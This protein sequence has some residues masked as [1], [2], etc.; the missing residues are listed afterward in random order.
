[1]LHLS[2]GIFA[3]EKLGVWEAHC[4][5]GLFLVGLHIH[6]RALAVSGP[7]DHGWRAALVAFSCVSLLPSGEFG[8]EGRL[9]GF[10]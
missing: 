1:M 10:G 6:G 4:Y 2:K 9:P 7:L 3:P 8:T 5:S